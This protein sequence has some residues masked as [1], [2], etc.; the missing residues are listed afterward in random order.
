MDRPVFLKLVL[1]KVPDIELV[2]IEGLDRLARHMGISDEKIGEAKILVAEAVINALEHAGEENQTVNVEFSLTL[3][4]LIIFVQDFGKGFELS[5][6][7]EPDI[8]AKLGTK[9]K[10]G[11]G[12]KLMKTLSDGFRID[13]DH[14]GTRITLT[15]HLR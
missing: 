10:R 7:A 8:S 13:S 5:S 11:W 9:H 6:V 1:P 15:K 3:E 2:A 12:L 4:K 14:E